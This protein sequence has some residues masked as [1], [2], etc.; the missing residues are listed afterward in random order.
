M[1]LDRNPNG[2]D[3]KVKAVDVT[4]T[5]SGGVKDANLAHRSGCHCRK[6]MCLKKYCECFQLAVPCN[7]S[8]T[9]VQCFNTGSTGGKVSSTTGTLVPNVS[10]TPTAELENR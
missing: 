10:I 9:C 7:K 6:S 5:A 4:V 8:C 2:F 3:A 1:I